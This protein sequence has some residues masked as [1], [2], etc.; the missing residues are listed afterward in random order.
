MCARIN[1]L[2]CGMFDT[3]DEKFAVPPVMT[4]AASRVR[5]KVMVAVPVALASAPVTA[6]VSCAALMLAVNTTVFDGPSGSFGPSSHAATPHTARLIARTNRRLLIAILLEL[7]RQ[8]EAE[9]H[10]ARL[11]APRK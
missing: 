1:V 4:L 9:I 3:V 2:P 7:S 5:L 10:V 6:V 11:P 8:I